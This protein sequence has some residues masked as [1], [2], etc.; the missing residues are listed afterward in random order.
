MARER[1]LSERYVD[2]AQWLAGFECLLRL[3]SEQFAVLT[4]VFSE[5][6]GIYGKLAEANGSKGVLSNS[7]HVQ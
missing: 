2:A 3:A 4:E 5:R 7:F 6:Y 1:L